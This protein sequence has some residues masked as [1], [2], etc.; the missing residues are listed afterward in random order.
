M[1]QP[2]SSNHTYPHPSLIPIFYDLGWNRHPYL[3]FRAMQSVLIQIWG[4]IDIEKHV[5]F[6]PTS[7]VL[8]IH[9]PMWMPKNKSKQERLEHGKKRPGHICCR[10]I[11]AKL[12]RLASEMIFPRISHLHVEQKNNVSRRRS[13][14]QASFGEGVRLEWGERWYHGVVYSF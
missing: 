3:W 4:F 11:Q 12:C 14:F 9:W 7:T 8:P 2:N 5:G 10:E 13:H 1:Y 6:R